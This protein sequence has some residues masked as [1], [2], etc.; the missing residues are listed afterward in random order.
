[1]APP[2]L[3]LNEAPW[4]LTKRPEPRCTHSY[5]ELTLLY[6]PCWSWPWRS[7]GRTTTHHVASPPLSP[8]DAVQ[9][10]LP[11][12]IDHVPIMMAPQSRQPSNRQEIVGLVLQV[13]WGLDLVIVKRRR[14]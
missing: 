12:I 13:T 9:L 14:E 10:F 8:E 11:S 4:L 5:P 6:L 1:M 3:M 7:G 2:A